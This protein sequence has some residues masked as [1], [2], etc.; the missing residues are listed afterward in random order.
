MYGTIARMKVKPGQVDA[1]IA[2][3]RARPISDGQESAYIYQ[4]DADPNELYLV[5]MFS[6]KEAYVANANSPEQHEMFTQMMA[7]L[8]AE[9]EWHETHR[10]RSAP[11]GNRQRLEQRQL[12][13]GTQQL[14]MVGLRQLP[15]PCNRSRGNVGGRTPPRPGTPT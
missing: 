14:G 3:G 4:M 13:R 10:V 8:E 6:S 5:A 11:G 2:W 15:W 1:M 7:F 9:P 12:R